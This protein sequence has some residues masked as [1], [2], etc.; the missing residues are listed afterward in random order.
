MKRRLRPLLIAGGVLATC[1]AASPGWSQAASPAPSSAPAPAA[2]ERPPDPGKPPD[3]DK[4]PDPGKP[5]DT[6]KEPAAPPRPVEVTVAPAYGASNVSGRRRDFYHYNRLPTGFYLGLLRVLRKDDK[7]APLQEFWYLNPGEADSKAYLDV[8]LTRTPSYLRVWHDT[9]DF[10]GDP[11]APDWRFS[12]R[13][14]TR[15]TIQAADKDRGPVLRFHFWDQ[16]ESV[17][18]LLRL[19]P[20]PGID[21]STQDYRLAA[22]IPVGKGTL[23]VEP[24]VRTFDNQTRRGPD[25]NTTWLN[26]ELLYPV[27]RRLDFSA[28]GQHALTDVDGRDT[29][30]WTTL[31]ALGT[32]RAGSRV[33]LGAFY[34]FHSADL[35]FTVTSFED[36]SSIA[37]LDAAVYPMRR[38]SLQGGVYREDLRRQRGFSDRS[39]NAGYTGGWLRFRASDPDRW[40]FNVRLDR[41]DLDN[42]PDVRIPGLPSS[43][44]LYY[45]RHTKVDA[46]FDY[47]PLRRLSTYFDFLW[48]ERE[49]DERG[50]RVTLNSYTAGAVS[51]LTDRLA[52]TLEMSQQIWDGSTFPLRSGPGRPAGDLPPRFFFSDGRVFTASLGYRLSSRDALDFSFNE[53]TSTGG[54]RARDH[55]AM[56]QYRRDVSRNFFY[57]IGYQY[58]RFRDLRRQAAYTALPLVLQIGYRH[59]FR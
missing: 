40:S 43:D 24:R 17:P 38:V 28:S 18:D 42:A 20:G 36:R 35:P 22:M 57:S 15:L 45:S 47:F 49:N 46:R 9:T 8:P 41:Q 32:Y 3:V 16:H 39:E 26:G 11:R 14:N 50:S 5:P 6:Q 1:A 19:R 52:V 58:D 37:G 51:P 21:F 10:N 29:A 4:P 25:S 34:R 23:R 7:G 48:Q 13:E 59:E 12:D 31:K 33:T 54:Q 2:G 30:T 44:A 27:T 56:L 55:F 53:F